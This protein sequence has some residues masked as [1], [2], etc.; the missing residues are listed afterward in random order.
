MFS[1]KINFLKTSSDFASR[2]YQKARAV[3]QKFKKI[4]PGIQD[5]FLRIPETDSWEF[6][7]ANPNLFR[8]SDNVKS[9]LD[10]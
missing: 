5:N 2:I 1:N 8:I 4:R 9:P 6:P 10:I 7:A 3:S